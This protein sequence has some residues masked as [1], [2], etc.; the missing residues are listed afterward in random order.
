MEAEASFAVAR[1]HVARGA[2]PAVEIGLRDAVDRGDAGLVAVALMRRCVEDDRL[3][4]EAHI[5]PRKDGPVGADES[6]DQAEPVSG[7]GIGGEDALPERVEADAGFADRLEE[8][9]IVG[10]VAGLVAGA[11]DRVARDH[12]LRTRCVGG[13]GTAV[14]KGPTGRRSRRPRHEDHSGRRAQ[15]DA[16]GKAAPDA[17]IVV[18]G[19]VV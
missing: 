12:H 6:A 3:A 8:T 18:I 10:A 17:E 7:R 1:H 16:A 5:G 9:D 4:G 11:I 13:N 19:R 14:E 2:G 15:I